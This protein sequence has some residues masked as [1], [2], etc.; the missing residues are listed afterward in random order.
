M[1]DVTL[2]HLKRRKK[3][4]NLEVGGNPDSIELYLSLASKRKKATWVKY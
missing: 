4:S 3:E 2:K 1:K